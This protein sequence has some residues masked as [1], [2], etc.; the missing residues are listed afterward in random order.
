MGKVEYG[1]CPSGGYFAKTRFRM[2]GAKDGQWILGYGDTIPEAE[3]DLLK[4]WDFFDTFC[5][6]ATDTDEKT[7]TTTT[8]DTKTKQPWYVVVYN[9]NHN[10]FDNVIRW[11]QESCGHSI[12]VASMLASQIHHEGKA[13]VYQGEKHKCNAICKFLRSRGLQCEI[14]TPGEL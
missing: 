11:L 9:D 7:G 1:E 10:T 3:R 5:G 8:E 6:A 14:D 4:K 12:M 13:Q 2:K